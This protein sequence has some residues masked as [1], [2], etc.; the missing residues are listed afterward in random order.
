MRTDVSWR[1]GVRV[2]SSFLSHSGISQ[3]KF[4]YLQLYLLNFH[5]VAP[6]FSLSFFFVVHPLVPS[7][8]S[9]TVFE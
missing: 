1:G 8:V 6:S 5:Q 3:F 4:L 2:R 9:S 7:V